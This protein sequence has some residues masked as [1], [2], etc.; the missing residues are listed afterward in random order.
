VWRSEGIAPPFLTSALDGVASFTSGKEPRYPWNRRLGWPQ[1][2]SRCCALLNKKIYLAPTGNRALAVQSVTIPTELPRLLSASRTTWNWTAWWGNSKLWIKIFLKNT[3][4]RSI[5]IPYTTELV[6][7]HVTT[8]DLYSGGALVES[9]P[10]RRLSWVSPS[11]CRIVPPLVHD[12]FFLNIVTSR[13]VAGQR[14]RVKQ[15]YDS[16]C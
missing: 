12:P 8:L 11:K 10:K 16:C 3:A 15:L 13:P 2:R 6:G 1:S 7:T 14:P 9:L 4:G 5:L